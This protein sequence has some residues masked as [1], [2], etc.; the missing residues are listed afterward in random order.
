MQPDYHQAD[1]GR[2]GTKLVPSGPRKSQPLPLTAGVTPRQIRDVGWEAPYPS[3]PASG[4]FVQFGT[5]I[6]RGRGGD[7]R[8]HE[9]MPGVREELMRTG[10]INRI[11]EDAERHLGQKSLIFA[12]QDSDF[13]CHHASL[14]L[15]ATGFSKMPP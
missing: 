7:H 5:D 2:P 12:S 10:R 11:I 13:Y 3:R 14:V 4:Y 1:R 9:M 15:E 8:D 6:D